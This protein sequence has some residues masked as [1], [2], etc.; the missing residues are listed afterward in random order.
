MNGPRIE[1][2]YMRFPRLD[3]HEGTVE[4][5]SAQKL[6]TD[7]GSPLFV[8]SERI[9]REAYGMLESALRGAYPRARIAYSYKTNY[10]PALCAF[11]KDRGA[12]AEAVSGFEYWLAKR[13]G[14]KGADII[15]NGPH[16]LDSELAEALSDGWFL[17]VDNREELYRVA[18]L[19]AKR[20]MRPR[21]G[22]R[23]NTAFARNG[24][25]PWKRFGFDAGNGEAEDVCREIVK[26]FSHLA[27]AGL[28]MHIGTNIREA[29]V[30][31][32]AA[33]EAADFALGLKKAFGVEVDYLDMGGGFAVAGDRLRGSDEGGASP[34]EEYMQALV[35]P[36]LEK[37]NWQPQLIVEPGRYLVSESSVLLTTVVSNRKAE[38]GARVTVDGTISI[39]REAGFVE[40]VVVA[41]KPGAGHTPTTIFGS[42]C[43]QYDVLGEAPLPPLERGDIV[44][45]GHAGAYSISRS[46]QWIFPR[47]AVVLIDAEGEFRLV[48][49]REENEDLVRLDV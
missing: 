16:K 6:L 2:A 30:F 12:L 32:S 15:F 18:A 10:L 38:K 27:L 9:L 23:L 19:A 26:K 22:I 20:K 34:I 11:F 17:N 24:A 21:I 33:A 47:P 43:T 40:T 13:L 45:L 42:S 49:K 46:S 28:H 39:L 29:G 1:R 25:E 36:V 4:G 3:I 14:Y 41:L 5:V 7:F 35:A 8:I 31:R 37:L 44:V 48:R